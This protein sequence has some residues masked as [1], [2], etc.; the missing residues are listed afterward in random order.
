MTG[1]DLAVVPIRGVDHHVR[2]L[3]FVEGEMFSDAGYLGD[4]VLGR[5]GALAA[6]LSAAL[7]RLRA[8]RGDRD[9][10]YDTRHAARVV[11]TLA[12]SVADPARRA[13]AIGL[14]DRAWAA[15]DAAGRRS[16][17]ARS[18]TPTSPTTTSSRRSRRRRAADARPGVIDFGDVVRSW[19][20]ADLA[21]AITSLLVR[22][23]RSP[24]LDA[25]AVVAGFHAVTPLTEAEIA[26]VWPLVAARACV[27]AVERG[28]HPGR[29]SRQR[30]TPA[31]S[32]RWTG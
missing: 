4:E 27:L 22:D 9:L 29:R 24:V 15:L 19:L 21:T 10:Q 3:T 12:G 14:S 20:V 18:C 26:A 2:L 7:A 31:R 1:A 11:D 30:R 32:S 16:C 17:A 13:D 25:A 23:R 8:P 6:R 5:F 28:R